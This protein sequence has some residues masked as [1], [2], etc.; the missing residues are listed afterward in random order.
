MR[1]TCYII[2]RFMLQLEESNSKYGES[3]NGN[4]PNELGKTL[5]NKI[6]NALITILFWWTY[7]VKGN[8]KSGLLPYIVRWSSMMVLE[9]KEFRHTALE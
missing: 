6:S 4:Q 3:L 5:K 2:W 9:I 1:V 8:P 7:I